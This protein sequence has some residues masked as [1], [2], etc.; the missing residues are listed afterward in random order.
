M[1]Q[2]KQLQ[3]APSLVKI[4]LDQ[5]RQKKDQDQV[6]PRLES[7]IWRARHHLVAQAPAKSRPVVKASAAVDAAH[8]SSTSSDDYFRGYRGFRGWHG[9]DWGASSRL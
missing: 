2:E 6:V 3:E 7:V 5:Q 9:G 1:D 4:D 8:P